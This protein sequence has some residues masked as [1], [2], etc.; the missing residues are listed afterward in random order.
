MAGLVFVFGT[1]QRLECVVAAFRADARY[2]FKFFF[3]TLKIHYITHVGGVYL[4]QLPPPPARRGGVDQKPGGN[5]D[6]I[7]SLSQISA[8]SDARIAR[9]SQDNWN[10]R[11]KSLIS[12]DVIISEV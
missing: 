7:S 12:N 11:P 2:G 1:E 9:T 3:G 5:A 10:L 6:C 8:V 4:S